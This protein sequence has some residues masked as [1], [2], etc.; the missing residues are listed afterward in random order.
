[1]RGTRSLG[2]A[3]I[4]TALGAAPALAQQQNTTPPPSNAPAAT[5]PAPSAN[6]GDQSKQNQAATT[7]A[8][9]ANDQASSANKA[10][11]TATDQANNAKTEANNA[12]SNANNAKTEANKAENNA[13]NAKAEANA[14]NDQANAANNNAAAAPAGSPA[15]APANNTAA[16]N[17]PP[18]NTTTAANAK[19]PSGSLKKYNGDFRAGKLVGATVFDSKGEDIGSIDDLLVDNDGKITHAVVSTGGGAFGIGSKLVSV[20]FDQFKFEESAGSGANTAPAAPANGVRS[21]AA[22]PGAGSTAAN[23]NPTEYS[24]VLPNATKDSLGKQQEFKYAS[25]G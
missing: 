21:G 3:L 4:A 9:N 10:A 22:A 19:A 14:A 24:V 18:S 12:Q 25:A 16:T 7:P 11:N 5:T 17:P 13:G 15:A 1:M 8:A 20:P 2:L 6:A 23:N